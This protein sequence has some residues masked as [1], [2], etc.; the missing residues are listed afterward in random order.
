MQ[1]QDKSWIMEQSAVKCFP[2]DM[3]KL[4]HSLIH[5]QCGYFHKTCSRASQPKFQYRQQRCSPGPPLTKEL[6]VTDGC[7]EQESY[8]LSEGV[9]TSE[10]LRLYMD[11]CAALIGLNRLYQKQKTKIK[12]KQ[13]RK[14][15]QE[16]RLKG[17]QGGRRNRRSGYNISL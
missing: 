14:S 6:L 4:L 10:F 16:G 8:C 17:L 2:Q 13:K 9:V 3:T 11:T 7:Q 5:S 12:Q 1:N 15:W